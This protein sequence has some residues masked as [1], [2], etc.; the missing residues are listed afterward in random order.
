MLFRKKRVVFLTILLGLVIL[1][2]I[3][4]IPFI[5][6]NFKSSKRVIVVDPG[7]GGKDPGTIGFSG[8]YE[9][10]VN[11]EISKKL[12]K[13]LKSN[14][15]KVILTRDSDEYVDNLLRAKTAN[16]KRARVFISIH[17]NSMENN[18]SVDGVQVLYYPNR[19]STIGDLNNNELAQ[20]MMNSMV[21]GTGAKDKGI[22]ERKNLIVLNQTK[23]PAIII[24]CG[25]LS[26]KNEEKLLLTED[27]QNKIVDSI[28]DGLEEYLSL[29][30][31]S[32][33]R[34]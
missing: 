28:I 7:H 33:M 13:K 3:K 4:G 21:N 10:E 8:N 27:Y 15:Y 32:E 2:I 16:K 14:G 23:M 12:K 25:F 6:R 22:I 30:T 5:D 18:S 19:E 1:I 17:C 20:I 24:E 26:N 31:G 29:N 34:K 11:L 9:K